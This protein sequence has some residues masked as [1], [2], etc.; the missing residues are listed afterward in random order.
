MSVGRPLSSDPLPN[1]TCDFHRIRLSSFHIAFDDPILVIGVFYR[2]GAY[3]LVGF[4]GAFVFLLVRIL[5]M[6]T[7]LCFIYISSACVSSRVSAWLLHNQTRSDDQ[8]YPR[9]TKKRT[10]F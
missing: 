9:S 1:R 8:P 5:R 4:F 3:L 7:I 2:F 6:C 10:V